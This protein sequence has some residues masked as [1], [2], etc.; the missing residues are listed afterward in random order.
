MNSYLLIKNIHVTCAVISILGFVIRGIWMIQSSQW[1]KHPLVKRLPHIV[2]SLLL[3]TALIMV[4]LSAQYPFVQHWLTTKVVLL[5]VYILLGMMALRWLK[6]KKQRI[7][8]WLMAIVVYVYILS[9]A[10]TRSSSG[11]MNYF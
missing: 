10:M 1:L 5:I 6:N 7:I 2:D 4:Y 8:A 9:V 3:L 11:F